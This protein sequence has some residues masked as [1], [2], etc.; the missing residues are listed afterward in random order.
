MNFVESVIDTLIPTI[1]VTVKRGI[2]AG[3]QCPKQDAESGYLLTYSYISSVILI[4]TIHCIVSLV[5]LL[6]VA[7]LSFQYNYFVFIFLSLL[8]IN[9]GPL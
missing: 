4:W 8:D 7:A 3:K 6:L 2:Y 9:I 5:I 1:F